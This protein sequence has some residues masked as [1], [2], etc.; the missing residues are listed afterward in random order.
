MVRRKHGGCKEKQCAIHYKIRVSQLET[1][2]HTISLLTEAFVLST[3]SFIINNHSLVVL[4][5][6]I[7]SVSEFQLLAEI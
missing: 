4:L 1:I 3:R 5:F 2:G 6:W 7:R